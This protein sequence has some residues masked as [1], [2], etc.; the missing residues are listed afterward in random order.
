M[1]ALQAE[2]TSNVSEQPREEQH[3]RD[4]REHGA[5]QLAEQVGYGRCVFDRA[6][7]EACSPTVVARSCADKK[8]EERVNVRLRLHERH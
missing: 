2:G 1:G 8:N 3:D 5:S 4:E 7:G 6:D